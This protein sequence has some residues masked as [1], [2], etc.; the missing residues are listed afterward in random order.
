MTGTSCE[1]HI[2]RLRALARLAEGEH[3]GP[4]A[5]AQRLLG[6]GCVRD[7]FVSLPTEA[8]LVRV[9]KVFQVFVRARLSPAARATAIARCVAEWMFRD[10]AP[11]EGRSLVISEV[12]QAL[13]VSPPATSS[14]A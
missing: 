14:A 3:L 2:D 6:Q 11:G 12:A 13:S 5:L 7:D 9:G 1:R 10:E 8:E 4:E